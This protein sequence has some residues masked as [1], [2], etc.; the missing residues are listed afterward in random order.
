MSFWPGKAEE[1]KNPAGVSNPGPGIRKIIFHLQ[2]EQILQGRHGETSNMGT[3]NATFMALL[4]RAKLYFH[5]RHVLYL[6][7][8]QLS[9]MLEN[10]HSLL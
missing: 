2:P 7:K 3:H 5:Y 8:G 4:V 1:L 6:S 9:R 10:I